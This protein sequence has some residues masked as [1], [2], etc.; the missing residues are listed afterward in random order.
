MA[1][2]S[3]L[4]EVARTLKGKT[5]MNREQDA[6]YFCSHL[7]RVSCGLAFQLVS[8]LGQVQP[9]LVC[10]L[11]NLMPREA[12]HR[13]WLCARAPVGVKRLV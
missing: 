3:V 10:G 12:T 5:E 8:A 6:L 7:E 9:S 13:E 11:L 1:R 2:K 4:V